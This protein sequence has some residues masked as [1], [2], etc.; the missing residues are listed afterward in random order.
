MAAMKRIPEAV[1]QKIKDATDI[2][3]LV[4]DYL[5][6]PKKSGSN[7]F[8]LCPFHAEKTA[9]F[10][11]NPSKQ[12]FYCFGCHKGGD[13]IA[14][15]REMEHLD[16][17]SA[18]RF[19]AERAHIEIP[20]VD[21][22]AYLERQKRLKAL[23]S[24]MNE[25]AYYFYRNLFSPSAAA[26]QAYLEK[27][28]IRAEAAKRFGLGYADPSWDGLLRQLTRGRKGPFDADTLRNS[29]LFTGFA[30]GR[31]FD[32]FRD[33]LM[34]P[35]ISPVG[36]GQ[37]L[38][39]GGRVLDDS[40][41]KYIN[42]PE[43]PIYHKRREVYALNLAKQSTAKRFI[44]AEG[45]MDVLAL[46][47]AGFDQAVATLGTALTR[48]Q[49]R[50]LRQYKNGVSLCFDAD[51]A[52]Q[53][54]VRRAI[55]ILEAEDMEVDILQIPGAKDPDALIRTQGSG[56][57]EDVLSKALPVLDYR[58]L[59]AERRSRSTAETRLDPEKYLRELL[60]FLP[61]IQS[62]SLREVYLAKAA[63]IMGVSLESLKRDVERAIR[64]RDKEAQ[65]ASRGHSGYAGRGGPDSGPAVTGPAER[66]GKGSQ[67]SGSRN[68]PSLDAPES[69]A[70]QA[71]ARY[72]IFLSISPGFQEEAGRELTS[73]FAEG[74]LPPE[75]SEAIL[76]ALK[77]H[78]LSEAS[79]IQLAGNS[80]S[81]VFM[82][83]MAGEQ[84]QFDR[85]RDL[86]L[87]LPPTSRGKRRREE[88]REEAQRLGRRFLRAYLDYRQTELL[89]RL[90][91]EDPSS[92]TYQQTQA[93]LKRLLK[94]R[95]DAAKQREV[96]EKF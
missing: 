34:F 64:S 82:N 13:A 56:A 46:H 37:V 51:R 14:F 93:Q 91:S 33:R 30:K 81:E 78:S 15:V 32:L 22:K 63:E 86:Q 48:E 6:L 19:L 59:V 50:L 44:L 1:I 57:F 29:G 3:S 60:Q 92:D 36:K 87:S 80:G 94:R 23:R 62:E 49:A 41:P 73:D 26:A 70:L 38:A 88:D 11:V 68:L 96:S 9:S 39:F 52:G 75:T 18:I 4:E 90:K 71:L 76:D 21:D 7:Y 69:D 54:A 45:Y 42:S 2:V 8:G 83:H 17:P 67:A 40:L 27:R 5:P 43:T 55:P 79:L 66:T 12:I 10:S 84:I 24:L 72:L 47:Q 85:V 77:R 20:A 31:R 61:D 35:I 58:L 16:Y 28:G 95:S 65:A 25:A 53:E 74:L 89:Q